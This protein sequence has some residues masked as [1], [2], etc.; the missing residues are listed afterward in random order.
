MLDKV[1]KPGFSL[2]H[3]CI[4]HLRDPDSE[5]M[6]PLSEQEVE[7]TKKKL[8]DYV[9]Y[10]WVHLGDTRYNRQGYRN[11]VEKLT[12]ILNKKQTTRRQDAS[13]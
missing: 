3:R 9:M 10:I 8:D 1:Y 4:T 5:Y 6:P 12:K 13:Q 11:A 2:I 7:V